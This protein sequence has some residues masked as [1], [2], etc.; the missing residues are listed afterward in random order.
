MGT[1]GAFPGGG[2]WVSA[3]RDAVIDDAVVHGGKYSARIE[4]GPSS[5]GTYSD[6]QAQIPVDFAG[7]S[8]ELRGFVKTESVTN[9]VLLEF[10]NRP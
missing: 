5:S 8:I 1:P 3:N 9:T 6:I 2:W 4:R 10:R 7:A